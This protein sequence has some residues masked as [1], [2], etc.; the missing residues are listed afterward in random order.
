MNEYFPRIADKVIEAELES[1]GGVLIEGPK[2]IG[3]TTTA[4]H[5]AKSYVCLDDEQNNEQNINLAL[6][7][8]HYLLQ[9]KTPR[10]IDEW[11]LA[12]NIWDAVRNEIDNRNEV[13]Q[14]ILTGSSVPIEE[15]KKRHSGI[16]R[17]SRV[18]MYPMSLS[19]SQESTKEVSLSSLFLGNMKSIGG[20]S[21]K[22]LENIAYILC[23]GGWPGTLNISKGNAL[24]P[25]RNYVNSLIESD[26]SRVDQK[27]RKANIASKILR[28][29]ARFESS[30]ASIQDF[31]S[32]T[33]YARETI[34]DY[35]NAFEKLFVIKEMPAW[36][37]NLRSKIAIRSSYV[38]H[39]I[40]PSLAVASLGVGPDDLMNDLNTFGLLFESLVVRDLRIYSQ[41]LD[42]DVYHYRDS[43]G[44]ECDAVIHLRN[45]KYG[46]VEVKLASPK[47]IEEGAEK[48]LAL[49]NKIDT[50]R[51]GSPS[52]L[53]IVTAT[54]YAYKRQDGIIVCP[55]S[56]LTF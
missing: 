10:L 52:F 50:D 12:P 13:G 46:L 45:G 3:K 44:L 22:R 38:R 1:M 29:Y 54:Q 40:D 11:Q 14:F 49:K 37:P 47:G 32:D 42:G 16:G 31:V 30:E 19:E 27:N 33:Q 23:R 26:I 28:S 8:P 51:M 55:L 25:A 20:F 18:F 15:N 53:M 39:F 7:D 41:I 6:S 56:C 21:D 34:D 5:I 43:K 2:W 17:I 35:L 48:L 4:K 24:R 36:N 9:G